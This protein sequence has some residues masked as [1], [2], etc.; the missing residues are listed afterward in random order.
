MLHDFNNDF[1]CTSDLTPKKNVGT[2]NKNNCVGKTGL[3]NNNSVSYLFTE[4]YLQ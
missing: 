2:Q 1:F 4:K 3:L